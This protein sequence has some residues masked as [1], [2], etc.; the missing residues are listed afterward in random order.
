MRPNNRRQKKR[1]TRGAK[2]VDIEKK[3]EENGKV[4]RQM[5]QANSTVMM[6]VQKCTLTIHKTK[7]DT[8]N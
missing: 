2:R 1:A 4:K 6:T 5:S 8:K 3:E 7:H